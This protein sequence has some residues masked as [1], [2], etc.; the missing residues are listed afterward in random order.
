MELHD[1]GLKS[2]GAGALLFATD[3]TTPYLPP[4]P[5]LFHADVLHAWPP[6]FRH[7]SFHIGPLRKRPHP[8]T[9]IQVP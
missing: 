2:G 5:N 8:W 9:P 7:L 3:P 4:P 1:D 6:N